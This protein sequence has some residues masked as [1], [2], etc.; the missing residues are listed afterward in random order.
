MLEKIES[1]FKEN[2][3]KRKIREMSLLSLPVDIWYSNTYRQKCQN[4]PSIS[5]FLDRNTINKI[6]NTNVYFRNMGD[7][8]KEDYLQC[9]P[10]KPRVRM[11][12]SE[13]SFLIEEMI[14]GDEYTHIEAIPTRMLVIDGLEDS[15][16]EQFWKQYYEENNIRWWNRPKN[17]D[18]RY[19]TQDDIQLSLHDECMCS[20][21]WHGKNSCPDG[22]PIYMLVD[23]ES[24]SWVNNKKYSCCCKDCFSWKPTKDYLADPIWCGKIDLVNKKAEGDWGWVCGPGDGFSVLSC[25]GNFN[26]DPNFKWDI[27][28]EFEYM[29]NVYHFY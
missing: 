28:Q 9:N 25:L 10:L 21:C 2:K 17:F 8:I 19:F 16:D 14:G 5:Q 6:I 7:K 4:A 23:G 22:K 20:D 12:T 11:L 24:Y 3:N 15:R 1:F 26:H 18:L 27:T 13:E 29:K